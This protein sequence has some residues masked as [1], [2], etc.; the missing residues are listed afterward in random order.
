MKFLV[1]ARDYFYPM[2][3]GNPSGE[4]RPTY[5]QNLGVFDYPEALAH[6]TKM[7]ADFTPVGW[8]RDY[9]MTMVDDYCTWKPYGWSD[10]AFA[11]DC[12]AIGEDLNHDLLR[13][14]CPCC[15]REI[16]EEE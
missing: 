15:G 11:T 2:H 10:G 9:W 3:R 6:I 4:V 7:R 16:R 12:G 14:D 1:H 13:K 5:R 8:A